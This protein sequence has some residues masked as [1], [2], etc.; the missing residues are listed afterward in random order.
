[1]PKFEI[2]EFWSK[3]FSKIFKKDFRH[4]R[5]FDQNL[6]V[7]KIFEMEIF[8]ILTKIAIF[9][10]IERYFDFRFFKILTKIDIWNKIEFSGN[11]NQ[12]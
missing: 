2:F 3:S 11:Y 10:E 9:P 5:K 12:T 1:M 4:F 8:K 7:S 6:D